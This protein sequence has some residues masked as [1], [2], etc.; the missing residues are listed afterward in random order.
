MKPASASLEC[1]I[2]RAHVP[3]SSGFDPTRGSM[4]SEYQSSW[5]TWFCMVTAWAK[6]GSFDVVSSSSTSSNVAASLMNGLSSTRSTWVMSESKMTFS[7]PTDS[8]TSGL[9]YRASL[10][11]CRATVIRT[12]RQTKATAHGYDEGSGTNRRYGEIT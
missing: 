4:G 11:E 3:I 9:V 5:G 6:T 8:N 2:P 10:N 12:R 1:A 7:K